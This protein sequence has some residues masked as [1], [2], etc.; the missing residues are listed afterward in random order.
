M[1]AT[2]RDFARPIVQRGR[3]IRSALLSPILPNQSFSQCGEDVILRFA[4]QS[5]GIFH[6]QYLD[7]GA[8][9]PLRLSNSALFY[10]MGGR[11]VN[12]EP[13][14]LL[15]RQ[16]PRRR[17]KDVNLNVG[18]ASKDG[19]LDFYIM[20]NRELSTFSRSAAE[21]FERQGIRISTVISVPV[22]AINTILERYSPAN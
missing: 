20:A 2:L 22:L 8:H 21:H 19:T 4:L 7:V 3:L 12:V 10:Q 1:G 14:P 17:P 6:P 15:F 5:L 13:D 9:D 11:G 16:F 18:I